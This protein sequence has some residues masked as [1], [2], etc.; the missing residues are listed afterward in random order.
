MSTAPETFELAPDVA[1]CSFAP[2]TGSAAVEREKRQW[3]AVADDDVRI[4]TGYSCAPTNPD[5]WWCPAVGYSMS[6]KHH[7]FETERVAIDKLIAELTR[8][9][10]V[11]TDNIEA[12]KLRR[13]NAAGQGRR[14]E[15]TQHEKET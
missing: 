1:R 7:L 2:V 15:D 6:E 9:I 14:A 4:V 12:L 3:W 8:K 13:Q 5:M 10:E 11:A